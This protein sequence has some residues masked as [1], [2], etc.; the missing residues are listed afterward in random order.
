MM[1]SPA[2]MQWARSSSS[3][4]V[5]SISSRYT[6]Q[7]V[8]QAPHSWHLKMISATLSLSSLRPE[9]MELPMIILPEPE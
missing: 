8:S 4:S 2:S 3:T 5:R 7:A 1:S 9:R 6:L